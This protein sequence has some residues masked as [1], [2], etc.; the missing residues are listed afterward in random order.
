MKIKISKAIEILDFN[1][2]EANPRMPE[3]C[4]A[5]VKLGIAGLEAIQTYRIDS[6]YYIPDC[7][8]GE[9]SED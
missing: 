8:E 9:E 1:I 4:E 6:E 2:K 5:A 7:L 3:D